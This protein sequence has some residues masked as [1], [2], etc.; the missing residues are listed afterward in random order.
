[1]R[2]RQN[3]VRL[4]FAGLNP[5][6]NRIADLDIYGYG[7]VAIEFEIEKRRGEVR[8]GHHGGKL[9]LY[10]PARSKPAGLLFSSAA[11]KRRAI[12]TGRVIALPTTTAQAPASSAAAAC[13]G[14]SIIP[15]A[16]TGTGQRC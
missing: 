11:E 15:S 14:V 4:K 12:V 6:T 8:S 2:G 9:L 7:A 3:G 5:L 1:M 10:S 16:I 13:C